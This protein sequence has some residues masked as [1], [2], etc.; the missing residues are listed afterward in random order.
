VAKNK[1]EALGKFQDEGEEEETEEDVVGIANVAV[2][3]SE[4][5]AT[6][7][8]SDLVFEYPST[9]D[10][11]G[12]AAQTT[13]TTHVRNSQNVT[14]IKGSALGPVAILDNA[15]DDTPEEGGETDL[16][17]QQVQ[18]RLNDLSFNHTSIETQ[19]ADQNIKT[20]AQ[21]ERAEPPSDQRKPGFRSWIPV[22]DGSERG[23]SRAQ[24]SRGELANMT[25]ISEESVSTHDEFY[26]KRQRKLCILNLCI[27][28]MILAAVVCSVLFAIELIGAGN[29][30][31]LAQQRSSTPPPQPTFPS[32]RPL[33]TPSPVDIGSDTNPAIPSS[34]V[35]SPTDDSTTGRNDPT[36]PPVENSDSTTDGSNPTASPVDNSE[37]NSVASLAVAPGTT[38]ER[39]LQISGD[40]IKDESTPQFA[41]YNWLQNQDPANLD[42]DS[43]SDE[44]LS[45]RYIAA[46]LYFSLDG[47]NWIDK[48]RFLDDSNVCEWNNGSTRN[49]LGIRCS[50]GTIDGFSVNKYGT[51]TGI[52]MSKYINRKC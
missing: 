15:G 10:S 47:N 5:V 3:S 17:V 44:E 7:V 46:L 2:Q 16:V 24:R 19:L 31:T 28:L 1:T 32:G 6:S 39:L 34:P 40:A 14:V 11:E 9:E 33:D 20:D 36:A 42:L 45:Q 18:R 26:R 21:T 29:E 43:L 41:A 48:Y 51:I 52:A 22:G 38:E 12:Q 4:S 8:N 49:M 13:R 30:D 27:I 23:R 35:E 25:V 37:L 50:D